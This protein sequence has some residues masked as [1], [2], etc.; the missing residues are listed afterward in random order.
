MLGFRLP[1]DA[2]ETAEY[3]ERNWR[4]TGKIPQGN[5]TGE[6][7]TQIRGAEKKGNGSANKASTRYR[8]FL[9]PHGKSERHEAH[10]NCQRD[11]AIREQKR[12]LTVSENDGASHL[13]CPRLNSASDWTR[14]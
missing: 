11:D 2:E 9:S 10:D 12:I 4:N 14:F 5:T 1:T 13:L 3:A 8:F 7:E 6:A